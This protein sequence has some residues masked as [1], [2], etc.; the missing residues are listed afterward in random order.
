[1]YLFSLQDGYCELL[2]G[3]MKQCHSIINYQLLIINVQY[4]V[5][6]IHFGQPI[7]FEYS[8]CLVKPCKGVILAVEE[9]E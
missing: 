1:V 5:K 3:L 6:A 4:S 8:M 9:E 2:I 7:D